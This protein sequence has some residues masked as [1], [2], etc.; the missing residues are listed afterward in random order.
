MF[1]IAKTDRS[2][3]LLLFSVVVL[4]GSSFAVSKIGLK[5][6]SP[7]NMAGSRFVIAS[8]LFGILLLTRKSR[9][10]PERRDI[11]SLAV[12]GFMSIT[13]Y[14]YIQYTGLLYTTSI[15]AALL[16]ATSP[17]WTTVY[18]V[19]TQHERITVKAAIGMA[20]AFV[21]ISLV[22]SK[23]RAFSLFTFETLQGDL[24]LLLNSIVWAGF[25]LYGK[26]IMQK[27]SPFTAMA[28][29][30]IFGTIMLLPVILIPSTINPIPIT[31]Q[32]PDVSFATG[33]AILYLAGLCSV[34]GYGMW[35]RGVAQIGAVRTASFYYMSPLI[36]LLAGVWLLNESINFLVVA[37]G[38]LVMSGV[39]FVNK[40]KAPVVKADP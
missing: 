28:Y 39:Y 7:L 17:I 24:L 18:C 19:A 26:K 15:N 40:Y 38:C 4:W 34:Y 13:S 37:G 27:Y 36:A 5:E 3:Y 35:Y 16:L 23:G 2:A 25:T 33:F 8:V 1:R 9:C 14:F 6:L 20:L 10:V 22:I 31:Q 32:L 12:A 21:G 11:L 29:I 30:H